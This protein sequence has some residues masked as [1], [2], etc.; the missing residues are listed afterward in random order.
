MPPAG[1]PEIETG[2][3][4]AEKQA[5]DVQFIQ[6]PQDQRADTVLDVSLAPS[7]VTYNPATLQRITSFFQTDEVRS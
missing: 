1:V 6:K 7:F 4:K 5:L 3:A 2:A